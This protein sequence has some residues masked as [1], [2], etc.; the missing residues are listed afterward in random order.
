MKLGTV[1]LLGLTGLAV[2]QGL[3]LAKSGPD[4]RFGSSWIQTDDSVGEVSALTADGEKVSLTTG[5]TL[6]LL[7]FHSQCSRCRRVIPMWRDMQNG[8][9][10]G[11]KVAAISGE[12]QETAA[13]FLASFHWHPDIWQ[14]GGNGGP[15]G[16]RSLVTRTPWAFLVDGKG[17]VLDEA[18][19]RFAQELVSEWFGETKTKA[20]HP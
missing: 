18:H 17:V 10:S 14:L 8:L 7:A 11:W 12:P 9:P 1:G 13:A 5:D 3:F 16:R 15:F 19:G 20:G 2:I 6:L 4:S